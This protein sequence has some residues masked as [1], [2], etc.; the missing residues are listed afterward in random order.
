M[1]VFDAQSMQINGRV[2]ANGGAGAGGGGNIGGTPGGN[3]STMQWNQRAPAGIG[4]PA[5]P[6]GPAGNGAEGTAT[7]QSSNVDGT[8]S[9]LGGGGGGGGLGVV[10][11]YGTLNG[12][13]M[14]SPA[15][16]QR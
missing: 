10:W 13:S 8:S 11:T 16:V 12:G 14:M 9:D 3:G 7:G 6:N 2:V 1:I 4:D 5:P 15:P